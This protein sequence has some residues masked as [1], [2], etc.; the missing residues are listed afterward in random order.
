MRDAPRPFFTSKSYQLRFTPDGSALVAFARDLAVW[1]I[2]L[3]KKIA[4]GHRLKHIAFV[5]VSPTGSSVLLKSTSGAM[6]VLSLPA[7][8]AIQSFPVQPESEGCQALFS[9][10]GNYV[11]DGSWSGL[12]TTRDLKTSELSTWDRHDRTLIVS[13]CSTTDRALFAYVVQPITKNRVDPPEPSRIVLRRWPFDRHE[14][15]I[16]QSN[17]GYVLAISLSP[18]G[19]KLAVLQIHKSGEFTL[20]VHSLSGDLKVQS[21]TVLWGGTNY[22]LAW[23]PN[24]A[25]IACVESGQISLYDCT[26]M[27]PV[28]K[29][30]V[31]YPSHVEFSPNGEL[32][33]IGSWEQGLVV[34]I[35]DLE[36]A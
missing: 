34:R 14:A 9:P 18:N 32:L 5:D 8:N 4:F 28:A 13:L 3:R 36:R 29:Q 19:G 26:T 15:E 22:S 24:G 20:G 27:S 10:C 21:R 35:E 2:P 6:C 7:L 31:P 33:A 16:I 25:T 12:L 1:S 30:S 23:S 11:I 17:W